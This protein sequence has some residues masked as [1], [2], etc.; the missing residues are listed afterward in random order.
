MNLS[1][2]NEIE[3][4]TLKVISLTGQTVLEQQNR[5]G[6]DFSVDV[7]SL[8]SGLYLIQI[9]NDSNSYISKFIKQ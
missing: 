4:G 5:S 8:N 1:F 3:S 6:T 2:K 9:N 7:S